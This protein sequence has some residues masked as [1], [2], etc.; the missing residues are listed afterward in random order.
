MAVFR[1]QNPSDK[2]D[3]I[4]MKIGS[5]LLL[6]MKTNAKKKGSPCTAVVVIYLPQP[7]HPETVYR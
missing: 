3:P 4:E 6:K 7:W 1:I 5:A 2:I